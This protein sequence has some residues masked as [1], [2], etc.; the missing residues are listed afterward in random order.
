MNMLEWKNQVTAAYKILL[1]LTMPPVWEL[2]FIA[3]TM[4]DITGD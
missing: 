2:C 3:F 4:N 1:N